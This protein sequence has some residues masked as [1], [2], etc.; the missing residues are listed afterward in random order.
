MAGRRDCQETL[1]L[2]ARKL[3]R[4]TSNSIQNIIFPAGESI[5]HGGWDGVLEVIQGTD[6]LPSGTSL[7]E[8]GSDRDPKT[9]AEKEYVKRTNN[10]LGFIQSESTS[11]TR[12]LSRLC[13][14]GLVRTL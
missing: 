7:W 4:A 1:P 9:K 10:P 12:I 5:Q 11:Y 6:I 8:F 14:P 2:L 13:T 3:I